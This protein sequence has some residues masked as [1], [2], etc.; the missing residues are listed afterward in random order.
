ME[1]LS[2]LSDGAAALSHC[3]GIG[4]CV[5]V[6]VTVA[7]PATKEVVYDYYIIKVTEVVHIDLE[8]QIVIMPAQE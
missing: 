6:R 3:Q 1:K 4:L 8:Y 5:C 7:L 2:L